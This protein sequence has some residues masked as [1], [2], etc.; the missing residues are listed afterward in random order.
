M[1]W[2]A[3]HVVYGEREG[4]YAGC[5]LAA[6]GDVDGDGCVDLLIGSPRQ[7]TEAKRAG[8]AHL[9]LGPCSRSSLLADADLTLLG[10]GESAGFGFS[11][12]L[13]RDLDGDGGDEL[14]VGGYGSGPRRES[15]GAVYVVTGSWEGSGSLPDLANFVVVGERSDDYAA[16][17]F[18]A[19]DLD[20]DGWPDFVVGA[21]GEDAG[22]D[23]A[24]AAY[25]ISGGLL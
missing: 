14:A 7:S 4:D 18:A 8:A 3:D 16:Y 5:A 9:I 6:N 19:G 11:V 17:V 20:A 21:P 12:Q 13:L 22:G 1:F 10:V 2:N 24:G 23:I 25:L 15:N